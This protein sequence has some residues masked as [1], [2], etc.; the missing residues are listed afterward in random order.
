M[1]ICLY[2]YV[3]C[4]R[5]I[6]VSIY[7]VYNGF[8]K[9]VWSFLHRFSSFSTRT[10]QIFAGFNDRQDI[11]RREVPVDDSGYDEFGRRKKTTGSKA[12]RAAAALERLKQKRQV[13][14]VPN[15]RLTV[16]VDRLN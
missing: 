12:E 16:L 1:T 2:V 8:Y 6:H 7:V 11:E 3:L 15:S 9:H 5:I 13:G 4:I 14:K 10:L